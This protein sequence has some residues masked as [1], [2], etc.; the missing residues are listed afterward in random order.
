MPRK[1]NP[2]RFYGHDLITPLVGAA[3]KINQRRKELPKG[4]PL[5]VTAAEDQLLRSASAMMR[6]MAHT[7]KLEHAVHFLGQKGRTNSTGRVA[8]QM[9]GRTGWVEYHLGYFF[10]LHRSMTDT[11]QWFVQEVLD[12]KLPKNQSAPKKLRALIAPASALVDVMNAIEDECGKFVEPRNDH[13]HRGQ[14]VRSRPVIGIDDY[15]KMLIA[16][17]MLILQCKHLPKDYDIGIHKEVRNQIA[18]LRETLVT[19]LRVKV[20]RLQGVLVRLL[21]VL[22]PVLREQIKTAI[23]NPLKV[24]EGMTPK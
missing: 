3:A 21:D 1:S 8:V 6:L 24:A 14:Y 13:L 20:D 18:E 2:H 4:A 23:E 15:E 19:I 17:S 12:L 22:A 16:D 5:P 9:L 7:A 10:T 11:V